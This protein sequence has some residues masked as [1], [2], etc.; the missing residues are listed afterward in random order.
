[1]CERENLLVRVSRLL[2]ETD[3]SENPLASLVLTE[4]HQAGRHGS[5]VGDNNGR[6]CPELELSQEEGEC[7]VPDE[8][9]L[10]LLCE[11]GEGG[12]TVN[13]VSMCGCVWYVFS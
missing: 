7:R 12:R 4:P 1:M 6:V 2:A 8:E 9:D 5:E 11:S 3:N 10:R 13:W